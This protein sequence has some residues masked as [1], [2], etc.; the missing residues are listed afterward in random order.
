MVSPSVGAGL[1]TFLSASFGE[2]L[3][4]LFAR[5]LTKFERAGR[6]DLLPESV[7]AC[8]ALLAGRA[9]RGL[10]GPALGF[11]G[12]GISE[13]LEMRESSSRLSVKKSSLGRFRVCSPMRNGLFSLL[14]DAMARAI[15]CLRRACYL[16]MML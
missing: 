1:G 14:R 11:E 10:T 3:S 16:C 4:S 8:N 15:T 6:L 12:E 5:A 7:A 2:G 9:R 13:T